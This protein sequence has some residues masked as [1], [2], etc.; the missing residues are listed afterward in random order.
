MWIINCTQLLQGGAAR[1]WLR[2]VSDISVKSRG[3]DEQQAGYDAALQGV[4]PIV[5]T[6]AVGY[7]FDRIGWRMVFGKCR[8]SVL[9]AVNHYEVT[10][11]SLIW[12]LVWA[13]A[14]FTKVNMLAPV[15]ISS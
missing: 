3:T 5:L 7:F 8:S 1:V 12:I 15:L 2:N 13:L 9:Q 4:I 10:T 14:G 6:P 11:T